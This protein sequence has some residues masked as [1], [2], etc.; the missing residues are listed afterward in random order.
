MTAA[1]LEEQGR[2]RHLHCD[3]TSADA[4]LPVCLPHQALK[5]IPVPVVLA[6]LPGSGFLHTCFEPAFCSETQLTMS[7]GRPCPT[8]SRHCLLQLPGGSN[9]FSSRNLLMM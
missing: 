3:A 6:A 7:W 9:V 2:K 8:R 5:I 4:I 1:S